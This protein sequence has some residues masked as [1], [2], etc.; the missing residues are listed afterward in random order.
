[1]KKL[2]RRF[3]H[4]LINLSEVKETNKLMSKNDITH[5][6][7]DIIFIHFITFVLYL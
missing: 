6:M 4:A 3:D 1:M 2:Q 7:R 5:E